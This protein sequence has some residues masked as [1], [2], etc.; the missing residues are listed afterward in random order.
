MRILFV[1]T[2]VSLLL[3]LLLPTTLSQG[4]RL[5][6]TR[7][8]ELL[9]SPYGDA[10]PFFRVELSL[11]SNEG[12]LPEMNLKDLSPDQLRQRIQITDGDKTFSPFYATP[13]ISKPESGTATSPGRDVLMLID[14]SYSMNNPIAGN[15][16]NRFGAAQTAAKELLRDFRDG[17]DFISTVPFE[18]HSVEKT[19]REA[20]FMG[21]RELADRQIDGLPKPKQGNNTGLYTAVSVALDVLQARKTPARRQILIVLTDGVNDVD[22]VQDKDDPGLEKRIDPVLE[23]AEKVDVPIY[24]VGLGNGGRDFDADLKSLAYPREARNYFSAQ[25]AGQLSEKMKLVQQSILSA[26]QITFYDPAHPDSTYLSSL[27]FK[28]GF[29]PPAGAVIESGDIVW[30]CPFLS[31]ARCP[32]TASLTEAEKKALFDF[33]QAKPAI[34]ENPWFVIL[35]FLG[36]L[37]ILSGVLVFLWFIPPRLLWPQPRFTVPAMGRSGINV[38]NPPPVPRTPSFGSKKPAPAQRDSLANHRSPR[39]RLDETQVITQKRRDV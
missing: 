19:I 15:A 3:L 29:H 27:N 17:V 11:V 37:A 31:S 25:D 2:V 12:T 34:A 5:E 13:L 23:K 21:T 1:V 32:A 39:R 10:R 8:V 24:T 38:P 26:I 9:Q 16:Q 35:K 7:K 30:T 14:T 28:V 33:D 22:H 6:K 4:I 36:I 20:Q 18:S